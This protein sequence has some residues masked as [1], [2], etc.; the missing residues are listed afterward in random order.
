MNK[1]NKQKDNVSINV[2]ADSA[3]EF[4]GFSKARPIAQKIGL[5]PKT[6]RRW[7]NLGYIT[8]FKL[9]DRI[10]LYSEEEIYGYIQAAKLGGSKKVLG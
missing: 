6:I 10:S 8:R 4:R 7:S 5:C 1:T 9:S 3:S 2:A